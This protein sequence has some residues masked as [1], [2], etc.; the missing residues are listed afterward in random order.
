MC[1]LTILL[2]AISSL[3]SA[4]LK[5]LSLGRVTYLNDSP[6]GTTSFFS[7]KLQNSNLASPLTFQ[8]VKV[9]IVGATGSLGP[10]TGTGPYTTPT[11]ILVNDTTQAPINGH[12]CPCL[13]AA[14]QLSMSS[15]PSVSITLKNGESITTSS[16]VNVYLEAPHRRSAIQ[17]QQYKPIIAYALP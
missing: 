9:A 2:L 14:F 17:L 4:Q 16:I 10:I 5:S 12:P 6:D 3:A 15:D 1:V 13:V 8:S 7:I 11:E